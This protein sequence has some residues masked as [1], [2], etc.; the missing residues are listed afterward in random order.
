MKKNRSDVIVI[1]SATAA[2]GQEAELE[3]ALREA[4]G[5]TREQP[6]CVEFSLYRSGASKSTIVGFERWASEAEHQKHLQGAHIQ[7]LMARMGGILAGPPVIVS[8]Q[9][10]DE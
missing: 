5:P 9:V 7:R 2:S 4:A 1:A 3:A 6:G 8:Y 10:I